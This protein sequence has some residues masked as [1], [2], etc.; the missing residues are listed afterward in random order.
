MRQK[1]GFRSPFCFQVSNLAP[2]SIST[3]RALSTSKLKVTGKLRPVSCRFIM[4]GKN[5]PSAKL[6]DC[7][8]C[9]ELPS[10]CGSR[11]WQ[12][13][14]ISPRMSGRRYL[15]INESFRDALSMILSVPVA[16]FDM[17][18][19]QQ[20]KDVSYAPYRYQHCTWFPASQKRHFWLG[21]GQ[22]GLVS[23]LRWLLLTQIKLSSALC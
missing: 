11:E 1:P 3:Q 6:P 17:T 14:K 23:L 9:P 7:S 8:M 4:F 19:L 18:K 16:T 22:D 21:I 15:M 13:A 20:N 12:S 5:K 2:R 10:G